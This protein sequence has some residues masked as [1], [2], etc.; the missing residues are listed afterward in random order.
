M[1]FMKI[2]AAVKT[3]M[4]VLAIGAAWFIQPGS[5]G[6]YFDAQAAVSQNDISLG[7][8]TAPKLEIIRVPEESLVYGNMRI[9]LTATDDYSPIQKFSYAIYPEGSAD[10][11]ADWVVKSDEHGCA[12]EECDGKREDAALFLALD[13]I[14]NPD[15]PRCS[16]SG[17]WCAGQPLPAGEYFVRMFCYDASNTV[18]EEGNRSEEII[19]RFEKR[20]AE[21]I[22]GL[23]NLRSRAGDDIVFPGVHCAGEPELVEVEWVLDVSAGIENVAMVPLEASGDGAV[24]A[25]GVIYPGTYKASVTATNKAGNTLSREFIVDV[26]NPALDFGD[27]VINEF[28]PD[29][30]G[31][32]SAHPPDGEWVE[33]MNSL[34]VYVDLLGFALYDGVDQHD[35]PIT[36]NT[37]EGVT[38]IAPAGYR[39]VFR[40]NQN[41][42]SLN[43]NG[44]E[45]VRLFS[46]F[47]EN[48]ETFL[49]GA[50]YTGPVKTGMSLA[51]H[52][53]GTGEFVPANPTPLRQNY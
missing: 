52:P 28:I 25:G 13:T 37:A 42:F 31:E 15:H 20:R 48:R 43:N 10:L 4:C 17:E 1:Q 19:Y 5:A 36:R 7:D 51:R 32:D 40:G 35:L 39:V 6:A 27:L 12:D 8:W 33:I 49:A 30:S 47:L 16:S 29:P 11:Q 9:F 45:S 18:Q 50:D 46:G 23:S 14:K 2:A 41:R 34:N 24:L 26:A 53:D 44:T 21:V 38:L 22:C 3:I